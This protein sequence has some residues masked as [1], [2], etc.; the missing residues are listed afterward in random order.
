MGAKDDYRDWGKYRK[1][2]GSTAGGVKKGLKW[3]F[4]QDSNTTVSGYLKKIFILPLLILFYPFR[5][6]IFILLLTLVIIF[7]IF[8]P[9]ISAWRSG[10]LQSLTDE[11]LIGV[12]QTGAPILVKTGLWEI[13][14]TW[15]DP[16]SLREPYDLNSK[17][18]EVGDYGVEIQSFKSELRTYLTENNEAVDLQLFANVKA[19]S[20][21]EE[22]LELSFECYVEGYG[23]RD[24]K[25]GLVEPNSVLI[26]SGGKTESNDV[27][28][29]VPEYKAFEKQETTRKA[30]FI[31][32]YNA[33]SQSKYRAYFL[34]KKNYDMMLEQKYTNPFEFYHIEDSLLD[35]DTREVTSESTKGPMNFVIGTVKGQT[36][37]FIQ[38]ESKVYFIAVMLE[39]ANTN[40]FGSLRKI[41]E[42][43]VY[44]PSAV[45]LR[46]EVPTR[47]A[48]ELT[49]ESAYI[50]DAKFDV[51]RVKD[52]KIERYNRDCEIGLSSDRDECLDFKQEM[53]FSCAFKVQEIDDRWDMF[54]SE[55]AARGDYEYENRRIASVIIQNKDTESGNCESLAEVDCKNKQGCMS[56]IENSVFV[57]CRSCPSTYKVCGD[58]VDET[59]CN[60]NKCNLGNC[61][62]ENGLCKTI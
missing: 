46:E 17:V 44:V 47:C 52:E 2:A 14:K 36:Q 50:G 4:D 5:S 29:L 56:T 55:F 26:P 15:R 57:N 6:R 43:Q 34:S 38:S 40:T 1:L 21:P 23:G 39:N 28:C 3:A 41:N 18:V 12:E 35:K 27:S 48:F 7:I 32:K 42:I 11:G 53:L 19:T 25:L 30:V 8:Y 45:K 58:Y 62:F 16:S 33:V 60:E 61:L 13:Y 22:D 31:V 37:P 54:Y 49:G 9:I 59:S 20:L 10:Y 24:K 51:Y